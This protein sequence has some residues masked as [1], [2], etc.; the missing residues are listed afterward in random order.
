MKNLSFTEFNGYQVLVFA[1]SSFRKLHSLYSVEMLFPF[2][3]PTCEQF[4]Y[5]NSF[6]R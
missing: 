4:Q 3:G 6:T 1:L 2:F 5:R